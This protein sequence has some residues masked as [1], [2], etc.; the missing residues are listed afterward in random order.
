MGFRSHVIYLSIIVALLSACGVESDP[1]G[2]TGDPGDVEAF[3]D[4]TRQPDGTYLV[5]DVVIGST[6]RLR[7]YYRQ[8]REGGQAL[9]IQQGTYRYGG[10][11]WGGHARR[12]LS[13]CISNAFGSHKYRIV[14]AMKEATR[15]W[16]RAANVRF[17]YLS[18]YDGICKKGFRG[19]VFDVQYASWASGSNAWHGKAFFPNEKRELRT[20]YFSA[21]AL[22]TAGL[23]PLPGLAKHEV[24]HVLGFGHEHM[25]YDGPRTCGYSSSLRPVTAYDSASV[26]HYHDCGGTGPYPSGSPLNNLELTTLD[27]QGAA[28][29]YGSPRNAVSW[30]PVR[31]TWGYGNHDVTYQIYGNDAKY[32]ARSQFGTSNWY[33]KVEHVVFYAS[34]IPFWGGRA[35]YNCATGDKIGNDTFVSPYANC[36]GRR[37]R[38]GRI[39]FVYSGYASG[40][41]A[42]YRCR[43]RSS[44]EHFVSRSS[45]CEGQLWEAVLGFTR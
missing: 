35:L 21:R 11:T 6:E 39:G 36:E 15:A 2:R 25:R 28:Q 24:G 23:F 7:A 19:T 41:A 20:I 34:P 17:H 33:G 4:A 10:F 14:Q 44:G 37:H 22:S 16:E 42:I 9:A 43:L 31:R 3:A 8:G 32:W 27:K 1:V 40:R 30:Q 29:V 5:D 38:G 13:Y 26:M 12:S 45:S 18:G